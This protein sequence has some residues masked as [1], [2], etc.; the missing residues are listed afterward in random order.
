M[1][2]PV[3]ALFWQS[4][5]PKMMAALMLVHLW[6][7]PSWAAGDFFVDSLM[8]AWPSPQAKVTATIQ[9]AFTASKSLLAQ[10]LQTHIRHPQSRSTYLERLA[11]ARLKIH[12]FMMGSIATISSDRQ[13]VVI[14]FNCAGY[15]PQA[16]NDQALVSIFLHELAH[17][18]GAEA[19][20]IYKLAA[21]PYYLWYQYQATP[22]TIHQLN[23]TV[24]AILFKTSSVA[25]GHDEEAL[26]LKYVPDDTIIIEQGKLQ[27]EAF[28]ATQQQVLPATQD[29]FFRTL[30]PHPQ[31]KFIEL[32][33][34]QENQKT[35]QLTLE[36]V[37]PFSSSWQLTDIFHQ[38]MVGEKIDLTTYGPSSG[39]AAKEAELLAD[40]VAADVLKTQIERIAQK[41]GNVAQAIQNYLFYLIDEVALRESAVGDATDAH[42]PALSRLDF[43]LRHFKKASAITPAILRKV[44]WDIYSCAQNLVGHQ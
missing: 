13:G 34:I 29:P 31:A 43:Y 39:R 6:G 7:V 28:T 27:G 16:P 20:D 1:P 9:K 17:L 37:A 8:N 12:P 14:N 22:R 42:L 33:F 25:G 2:H 23:P 40:W 30:L 26:L 4:F 32:N 44:K 36:T 10:W 38:E 18:L 3:W 21:G 24:Q 11:Q 41:G 35:I 19:N 5:I 15:L